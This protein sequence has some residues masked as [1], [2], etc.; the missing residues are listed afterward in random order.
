MGI[1]GK[2]VAKSGMGGRAPT[3][4]GAGPIDL[5]YGSRGMLAAYRR[6]G[7]LGPHEPRP[8]GPRVTIVEA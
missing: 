5:L 1:T 3:M 6:P 7:S 8:S 4:P 2:S